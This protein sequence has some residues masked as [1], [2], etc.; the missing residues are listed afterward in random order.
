MGRD[1][2]NSVVDHLRRPPES[3][4]TQSNRFSTQP[5]RLSD[6]YRRADGG[7]LGDCTYLFQ[8]EQTAGIMTEFDSK[9]RTSKTVGR[10]D[11]RDDGKRKDAKTE[12]NEK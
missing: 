7:W 2:A 12:K 1:S 4:R 3:P 10:K 5:R 8:R 9:A 6:G 11:G